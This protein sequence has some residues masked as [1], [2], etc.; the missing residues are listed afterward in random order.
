MRTYPEIL[1]MQEMFGVYN[2]QPRL[3]HFKKSSHAPKS[4][5]GFRDYPLDILND[6]RAPNPNHTAFCM[7]PPL[8]RS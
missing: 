3:S 7:L 8:K 6:S 1:D 2:N 5:V 4:T